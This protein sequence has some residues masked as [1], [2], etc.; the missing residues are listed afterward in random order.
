MIKGKLTAVY[1]ATAGDCPQKN[2]QKTAGGKCVRDAAAT[3]EAIYNA[4]RKAFTLHG[5]ERAGVREIARAAGVTAALVNRYFG[6][7]EKLFAEVLLTDD[8]PPFES[9]LADRSKFGES[10]ARFLI[11][12]PSRSNDFD[13]LLIFLRSVTD[14]DAA[15]VMR[16]HTERWIDPLVKGL[17]GPDAK[18]RAEM[19]VAVI[20]GF[21][22]SRNI[23]RTSALTETDEEDLVQILG[24]TLQ[25]FVD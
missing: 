2:S 22:T 10:F 8:F 4:A 17:N 3:R 11:T 9:F 25:S 24:R 5:Y 15:R 13:P 12:Q 14:P 7:K 18:V 6:S 1:D 16:A 19:I 20:C 21:Q 23:T